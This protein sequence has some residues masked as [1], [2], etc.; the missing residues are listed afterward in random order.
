MLIGIST[1]YRRTG[2]LYQQYR[3]HFGQD[4]ADTLVVQGSTLQ[5]N[6]TLTEADLAAQIAA[7]PSAAEAEWRGGFRDDIS[8]YLTDALLEAA[9]E[10]GRPLELPPLGAVAPSGVG[11]PRED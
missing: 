9:I 5:F 1:G 8:G 4:H 10:H 3:D 6:Q 2:L 7:D 11:Y